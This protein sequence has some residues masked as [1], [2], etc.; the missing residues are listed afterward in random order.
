MN[1]VHRIVKEYE[2]KRASPSA[3][4]QGAKPSANDAGGSPDPLK[5]TAPGS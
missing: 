2:G 4:R 5:K 3:F 1:L